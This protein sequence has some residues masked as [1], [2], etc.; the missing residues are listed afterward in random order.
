LLDK[1]PIRR[2]GSKRGPE[3]IKEHPYFEDVNWDDV[4]NKRI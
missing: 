2:L 3:E 1:N 4:L